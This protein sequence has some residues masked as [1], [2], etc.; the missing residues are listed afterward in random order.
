[1]CV[2]VYVCVHVC[3]TATSPAST[4]QR[5]SG[6]ITMF[7][8]HRVSSVSGPVLGSGVACEETRRRYTALVCFFSCFS[9]FSSACGLPRAQKY[10][11]GQGFTKSHVG[12]NSAVTLNSEMPP[13]VREGS[14]PPRGPDSRGSGRCDL[15]G[16]SAE[17]GSS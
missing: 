3:V 8:F 12:R 10:L 5:A 14:R 2:C 6:K 1:M 17:S 9:L 7:V 4:R 11:T 15:S 13:W 16:R